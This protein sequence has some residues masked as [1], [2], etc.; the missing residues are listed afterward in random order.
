MPPDQQELLTDL[1]LAVARLEVRL[2]S[3]D[4]KMDTA[5][6]SREHFENRLAP[7]IR[8]MDRWKGG[9]AAWL[10]MAGTAGAA[11]TSA[12]SHFFTNSGPK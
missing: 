5:L 12:V 9:L 7:L 8:H 10:F 1:R 6:V 11:I 2:G 3:M 4:D